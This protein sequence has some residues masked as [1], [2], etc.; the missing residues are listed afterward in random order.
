VYA[1]EVVLGAPAL[2]TGPIVSMDLGLAHR[3]SV[4]A[5]ESSLGFRSAAQRSET[6]ALGRCGVHGRVREQ[7]R[8]PSLNLDLSDVKWALA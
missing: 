5:S 6:S 8:C 7:A 1:I 2:L 4:E 3:A